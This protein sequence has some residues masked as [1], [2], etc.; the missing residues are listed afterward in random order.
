MNQQDKFQR[1]LG[2]LHSAALDDACQIKGNALVVGVERPCT[3]V[4][5]QKELKTSA[6][7]NEAVR[8]SSYHN[9]LNVHLAGQVGSHMVLA[10]ADPAGRDGWQSTLVRMIENLLPHVRQFVR[11][12][13]ALVDAEAPRGGFSELVAGGKSIVVDQTG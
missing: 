11:V 2:L 9:S 7:N 10:L 12:R 5:T 1:G 8:L 13:Q 3:D 6:T 4:Y